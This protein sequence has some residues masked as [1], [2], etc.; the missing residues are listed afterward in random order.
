MT[1]EQSLID[2]LPHPAAVVGESGV[3]LSVNEQFTRQYGDTGVAGDAGLYVPDLFR[4][5][6]GLRSEWIPT[7]IWEEDRVVL[8]RGL[9]CRHV[10]ARIV[11]LDRYRS[12]LICAGAEEDA[13]HSWIHLMYR[14]RAF[15]AALLRSVD[16]AVFLVD[17][18][19]T[20]L[21]YNP[22]ARSLVREEITQ[23]AGTHLDALLPL[24]QG[25]LPLAPSSLVQ[26]ALDRGEDCSFSAGITLENYREVS[27]PVEV[28]V[29]PMTDCCHP[30]P[31]EGGTACAMVT[32]RNVEERRR[33]HNDL[34]Y[35][36][37]AENVTR[38]VAGTVHEIINSCT[39][40]FAQL[41]LLREESGGDIS[42]LTT[43]VK[44]IQRLGYRLAGFTGGRDPEAEFQHDVAPGSV[45]E[46]IIN[47]V[48]LALSGTS[49]RATFRLSE[50]GGV[51]ALESERLAQVMFNLVTNSVE[52]MAEG[53]I[54]HIEST[55]S[56]AERV[57]KITVRDEGH[58]MDPRMLEDAIKPYFTTR[59]GG[60]GMGLT[61]AASVLKECGG[62]LEISTDPGFGTTVD[63]LIPLDDACSGI[64]GKRASGSP[65][66][67]TE[68]SMKGLPV[69]LVEDDN[70][71]RRSMA[72]SLRVLGCDVTTV[73]NG[74][75]ALPLLQSRL[76]GTTPFRLLIT[77]L[78]M[79]GRLDGVGLLR[80]VRE[81]DPDIP[82]ILSTGTVHYHRGR[83]HREAGFQAVLRKPF[84]IDQ[85]RHS[86]KSAFLAGL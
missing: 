73:E 80:R 86:I 16:H 10:Y 18:D 11:R 20:I 70:L 34:R 2:Y 23:L 30:V 54:V 53:G 42:G 41:D 19:C 79:P 47:A 24:C 51:P 58:G 81:L 66:N 65:E 57:L 40:L 1:I 17:C 4:L 78:T 31:G 36:Q 12:I 25:E 68:P 6:P 48:E 15:M 56:V 64:P 52:A 60:I 59:E 74:D 35:V 82:A 46:T 38:A 50:T 7:G 85:L 39:A 67:R 13:P 75:R 55:T 84:G 61:V 63:L 9:R 37:H 72:K 22:V 77:D 71:V 49:T 3:I 28:E 32:V 43:A 76:H 14:H 83:P 21:E 29:F 5:K 27:T 8:E 69:L 62:R 45:E 44:R 26:K 33:I